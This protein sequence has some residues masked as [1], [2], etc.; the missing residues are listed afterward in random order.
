MKKNV[1]PVDRIIRLILALIFG[2][3]YF[4]GS[5]TGIGGLVLLVLGII[6]LFTSIV[7]SCLIYTLLGISTAKKSKKK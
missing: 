6:F 7:N 1:G 5:V 4:T 2:I 3:L